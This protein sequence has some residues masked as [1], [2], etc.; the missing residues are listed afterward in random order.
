M[1]VLP[2]PVRQGPRA[3]P[4]AGAL[5][6]VM[7]DVPSR[8]ALAPDGTAVLLDDVEHDGQAEPGPLSWS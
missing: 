5:G 4:T 3:D 2:I 7:K 8:D 6:E 1:M